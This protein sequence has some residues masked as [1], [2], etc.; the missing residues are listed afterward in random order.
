MTYSVSPSFLEERKLMLKQNP[1]K[2]Y[3]PQIARRK[4]RVFSVMMS[5]RSD[6]GDALLKAS[7]AAMLVPAHLPDG[8]LRARC[9]ALLNT[10]MSCAASRCVCASDLPASK[11]GIR[12]PASFP[13]NG[14]LK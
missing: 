6:I 3:Y 13:R 11:D 1:K 10:L 7:V 4:H 9:Q 12:K 8:L 5:R 14:G 2:F